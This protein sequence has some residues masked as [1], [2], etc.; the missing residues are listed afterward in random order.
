MDKHI[1]D[2]YRS[3]AENAPTGHFHDVKCLQKDKGLLWKDLKVLAPDLCRGWYELSQLKAVDRVEFSKEYWLAKLPFQP[4]L[5]S[6]FEKFFSGI[7]DVRVYIVQPKFDDP[8]EAH[9]VYS[10]KQNE[11]FFRGLSGATEKDFHRLQHQFPKIIFPEDFF[12]FLQIHNGFSKTTDSGI[13][14]TSEIKPNYEFLQKLIGSKEGLLKSGDYPIDPKNLIP[15]YKSFGMPFFQC[16]YTEWYPR[17]EMG[18]VYYSNLTNTISNLSQKGSSTENM[19]F[20]TFDRW[21]M[22][23]L[24]AIS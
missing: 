17:N 9:L 13:L 11:G 2:F 12:A 1:Q 20:T 6:F 7:D 5:A 4:G 3:P 18:N 10:L 15:F 16:F 24:E 22:F 21:L 8:Y 23:Y 14:K 19:A